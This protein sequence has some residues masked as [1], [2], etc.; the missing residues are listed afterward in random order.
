MNNLD[1][2]RTLLSRATQGTRIAHREDLES[3]FISYQVQ[4]E[5]APFTIIA[6]FDQTTNKR[7]KYDAELDAK[8]REIIEGLVKEVEELRAA[9]AKLIDDAWQLADLVDYSVATKN[10]PH[11]SDENLEL[12]ARLLMRKVAS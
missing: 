4:R 9:N 12:V 10:P 8:A 2:I 7:A 6:C 11:V 1:D 5:D 3:G